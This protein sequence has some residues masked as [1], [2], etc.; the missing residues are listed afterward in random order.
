M[1][2]EVSVITPFHNV[3]MNMFRRC[4]ESM[5]AQTIGFEKIEWIVVLHNCEPEYHT[6]V[7]EL[8]GSYTNV[9]I[10]TLNNDV[11]SPSAPRN[12]G[13]KFATAPYLGF[14]DGDD[15]YTPKCLETAI[16]HLRK[17][18]SQIVVFRREYELESD[19]LLPWSEITLWNQ[20]FEEI[21]IDRDHMDDQKMFSGVWGIMTSRLYDREFLLRHNITSDE[22]IPYAEGALFI[23]EALGKADRICYLPQFIGYRYFING[24]SIV[25]SM[26]NKSGAVLVAYAVGMKKI[27]DGALNNGIA[28]EWTIA[29][30]LTLFS[31][32]LVQTKN[33]TIAERYTIKEILEPYVHMIP[34]LPVSKI[35]SEEDVRT[36]YELPREVILQPE[37]FDGGRHTQSLW[38]GRKVL[39]EILKANSATD[40]GLRYNFKALRTP[41]GYQTRV[42]LSTYKTYAPLID[43][44]TK[45][46]ERGIFVSDSV[47]CY[48]LTS[49]TSGEPRLIPATEKHLRPYLD[50]FTQIVSNKTT[51]ALFESLPQK[52]RFN[53]RS[54]LN[55]VSGMVLSEFFRR[56]R[57]TLGSSGAKFTSPETLMFP[58]EAMDT[59]YLRLL[60]ALKCRDVEQIFSP[61]TWGIVEALT[62]MET[63]WQALCND[64]EL[65]R[66]TFALDVPEDFLRLMNGLLLPD[67]A[68]ANELR[69][70][71]RE[72][73]DSP[74]VPRIWPK[75]KRV[76]AAGTGSYKIYTRRMK[77]Y[78]G[79]IEH[80]NGFFAASEFFMGRAI[81]GDDY[82]LISDVNFYEFMPIAAKSDARPLLI[83]NL[84]VGHSYEVIV[85]N[86]AGLYRYRTGDIIRVK[87]CGGG[88][89][90]FN[91]LGRVE[92]PMIT[93]D[94]IFYATDDT[95]REFDI[96]LADF[97]FFIGDDGQLT[98]LLEPVDSVVTKNF[99]DDSNFAATVDNA[100]CSQN[101]EYAEARRNGLP[102]CRVEWNQPQ[103]H[104]L[105]RDVRRFRKKTAP[106]QIKPTHYLNTAD[107]V[108]FFLSN[109]I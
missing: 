71:F 46:G 33:L 26:K 102:A 68:R 58:P 87:E 53:D 45:V 25:Q 72:G 88:Q 43:L 106:D 21:V 30:L 24:G 79:D 77:R 59:I 94:E 67:A 35:D 7:R 16:H 66:I 28:V 84:Q 4:C 60:F 75:L 90:V 103:S 18:N 1:A 23:I 99:A 29:T 92:Q 57:N 49:G 76:I 56:E 2:Y 85:T 95:C 108:K 12:H 104:L 34:L 51:F 6:A 39:I 32:A 27:F 82:E 89:I 86:R 64:I 11:H 98:I 78:L 22:T 54:F 36:F 15:G 109:R 9:I 47:L 93:I 10:E 61:F 20:T 38:D 42:P 69:E 105:Y 74:T 73:F 55:S 40:Y 37:N 31:Q 65:G 3:D 5:L 91:Y 41:E 100:I 70:I 52:K 50:A 8:L 62:F 63:N 83:S 107:K 14:L 44:Q 97:A 81:G 19:D 96:E 13:M 101:A 80:D 48:L 17:T